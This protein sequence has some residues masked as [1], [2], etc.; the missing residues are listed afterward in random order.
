MLLDFFCALNPHC[1]GVALRLYQS[2]LSACCC[3][4]QF[5][6]FGLV[7]FALL[8]RPIFACIKAS[9]CHLVGWMMVQALSKREINK[10]SIQL[11]QHGPWRAHVA[12]M[13]FVCVWCVVCQLWTDC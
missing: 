10:S 12:D 13:L 9:I 6:W 2:T 5:G 4:F 11:M 8:D 7:R 3:I 1:H